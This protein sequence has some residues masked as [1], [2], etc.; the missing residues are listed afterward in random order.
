M[1]MVIPN[2]GKVYFNDTALGVSAAED[3]VFRLYTNDYVPGNGSTAANFTP[4]TFAGSGAIT[5]LTTDWA[6]AAIVANV[7]RNTP[8]TAPEWTHG[9]GAPETVYGWYALTSITGLVA[10]AQRFDNA[11]VMNPGSI[12]SL[13]PA[14]WS[15]KT[16]A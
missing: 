16:F 12:E 5:I 15:V 3:L 2:E 13:A 11:R 7:A 1:N 9:G 14:E 4:A 6:G 10:M 8:A